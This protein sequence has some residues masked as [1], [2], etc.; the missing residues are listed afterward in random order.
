MKKEHYTEREIETFYDHVCDTNEMLLKKYI[1]RLQM[2]Q[3]ETKSLMPVV[4]NRWREYVGM[5]KLIKWQFNR[6]HNA[7]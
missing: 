3:D 7:T 4:W 5:R 1:T 2:R 6:C